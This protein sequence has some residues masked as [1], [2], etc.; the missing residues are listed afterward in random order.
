[1]LSPRPAHT[2]RLWL[3]LFSHPTAAGTAGGCSLSWLAASPH[4]HLSI[5]NS[6]FGLSLIY[7]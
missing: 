4:Q 7:I 6:D 2:D 1:M 3:H 5:T